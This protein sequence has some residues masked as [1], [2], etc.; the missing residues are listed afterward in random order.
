MTLTLRPGWG[1]IV[2]IAGLLAVG[3]AALV[4]WLNHHP[5]MGTFWSTH[6][7]VEVVVGNALIAATAWAIAGT[8]VM[9]VVLLLN[10]LWGAPMIVGVLLSAMRREVEAE[11]AKLARGD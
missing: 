1:L 10:V 8:G 3:Y 6:S 9:L 4:C 2:T 7:W 11:D 5:R